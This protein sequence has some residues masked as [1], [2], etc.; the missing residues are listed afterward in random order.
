MYISHQHDGSRRAYVQFF[1][2]GA[3][4]SVGE[5]TH[6]PDGQSRFVGHDL[7]SLVIGAVR[8]YLGVS[9][10]YDT[11]LPIYVFISLCNA[12]QTVYRHSQEGIGWHESN[13][14]GRE[15]VSL[16]EVYMQ[17]YDL[18]VPSA[19]HPVFNVLW[20]AVGLTQCDMYDS[21]GQWR[22]KR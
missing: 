6:E 20:N 22:K 5:L 1:R 7:T 17:N 3:I 21:H 12:S 13:P 9:K 10:S 8:Q 4:E 19:L 18:D 2:N 16:P 11:G 14:I 15:I